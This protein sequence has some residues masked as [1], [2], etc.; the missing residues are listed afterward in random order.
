MGIRMQEPGGPSERALQECVIERGIERLAR[1]RGQGQQGCALLCREL[2]A[3]LRR[4][5]PAGKSTGALEISPVPRHRPANRRRCSW[6]KSTSS[7]SRGPSVGERLGV[8][9]PVQNIRKRPGA[10]HGV[11]IG[12]AADFLSS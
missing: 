11:T 8:Q 1:G 12:T 10:D 9:M 4:S 3:W 7:R 5:R 6:A 2:P